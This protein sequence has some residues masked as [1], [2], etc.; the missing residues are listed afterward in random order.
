MFAPGASFGLVHD[1]LV[2]VS[3]ARQGNGDLHFSATHRVGGVLKDA[4]SVC[5]LLHA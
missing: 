4:E 5:C 1:D 3:E 2:A